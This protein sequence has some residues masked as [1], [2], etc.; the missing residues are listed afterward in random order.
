MV[1][2]SASWSARRSRLLAALRFELI[3]SPSATLALERS[4]A[5]PPAARLVIQKRWG[6]TFI[7]RATLRGNGERGIDD[8]DRAAVVDEHAAVGEPLARPRSGP[9]SSAAFA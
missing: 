8:L 9:E 2:E 7:G 4:S 6:A 5:A 1:S 3:I